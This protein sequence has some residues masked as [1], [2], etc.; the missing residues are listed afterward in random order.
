MDL[1]ELV[2]VIVVVVV[3]VVVVVGSGFIM[4]VSLRGSVTAIFVASQENMVVV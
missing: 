3:V 4:T 2:V 1:I